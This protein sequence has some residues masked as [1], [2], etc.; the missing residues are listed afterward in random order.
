[1]TKKFIDRIFA[2]HVIDTK[3]YRYKVGDHIADLGNSSK[4]CIMRMPLKF[5]GTIKEFRNDSWEEV[6]CK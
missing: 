1:M 2:N 4:P 6:W 3:K 5:V